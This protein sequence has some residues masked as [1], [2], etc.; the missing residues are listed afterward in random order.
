MF[1]GVKDLSGKI[2]HQGKFLPEETFVTRQKFRHFSPTT[3]FLIRY[4]IKLDAEH[5][6]T[7]HFDK[8]HTSCSNRA[9]FLEMNGESQSNKMQFDVAT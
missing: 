4:I 5:P 7:Y 6:S 9:Y 1:S 2:F 8:S 3:L